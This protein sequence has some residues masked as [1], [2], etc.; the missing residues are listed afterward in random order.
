VR[1]SSAW[2]AVIV[3]GC[4]GC[5]A[6]GGTTAGRAHS[7][8]SPTPK[9]TRA[10][11]DAGDATACSA[12][13][14]IYVTAAQEQPNTQAQGQELIAAGTAAHTPDLI[15]EAAAMKKAAAAGD[16]DGFRKQIVAMSITCRSLGMS[17]LG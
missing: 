2:V 10:G 7:A 16:L 3:A 6:C 11:P 15:K 1:A 9:A 4:L 8:T 12:L 13:R 14:A 5:G 17:P